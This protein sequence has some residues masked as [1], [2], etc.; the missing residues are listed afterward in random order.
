MTF[1][2]AQILSG[3]QLG[4]RWQRVSLPCT[5]PRNEALVL[6]NEPGDT[7]FAE[8]EKAEHKY[9][10][11]LAPRGSVR[12]AVSP[13]RTSPLPPHSKLR[14]IGGVDLVYECFTRP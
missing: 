5:V 11:P 14:A 3:S 2:I 7:A 6:G 13:A 4:V 9:D 8:P 1:S 12:K 10:Q